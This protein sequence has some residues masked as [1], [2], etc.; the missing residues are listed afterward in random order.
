M[1]VL[2]TS[3]LFKMGSL[4]RPNLSSLHVI[5]MEKTNKITNILHF[6][7]LLFRSN[8]PNIWWITSVFKMRDRYRPLGAFSIYFCHKYS[9][10]IIIAKSKKR[11]S[12]KRIYSNLLKNVIDSCQLYTLCISHRWCKNYHQKTKIVYSIQFV[13]KRHTLW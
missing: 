5:D 1:S 9:N 11:D 6:S 12:T 4:R 13:V 10:C 7:I 3:I 2:F 8:V